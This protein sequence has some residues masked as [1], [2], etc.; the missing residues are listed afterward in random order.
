MSSLAHQLLE[1]HRRLESAGV[2]HALGGAIALAFHTAEPRA[3]IDIDVNVFVPVSQ[4]DHVLGAIDGLVSASAAQRRALERDGQVRLF[5]DDTPIDLFFATVPFHTAAAARVEQVSF[6][7][8]TIP[9]LSATDLA[10]CKVVFGRDKDWA[11]LR[12]MAEAGTVDLDELRR[13]VADILGRD[14]PAERRATA[15]FGAE[16]AEPAPSPPSITRIR[17][18]RRNE[19]HP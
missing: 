11:D 14:S 6:E 15:L 2:P 7:G 3:T 1:L 13:W 17:A 18:A 9:I 19:E 8:A 12:A 16:Q 4:A 10:V 5:W